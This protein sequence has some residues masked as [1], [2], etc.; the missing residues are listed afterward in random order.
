MLA[1]APRRGLWGAT[2]PHYTRHANQATSETWVGPGHS[3]PLP[4]VLHDAR[5]LVAQDDPR[6]AFRRSRLVF[7]VE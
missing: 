5:A 2:F 3:P 6:S 4:G 1:D 7:R